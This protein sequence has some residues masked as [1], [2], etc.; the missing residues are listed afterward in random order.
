MTFTDFFRSFALVNID[1]AG[2]VVTEVVSSS[3]VQRVGP[4]GVGTSCVYADLSSEAGTRLAHTFIDINAVAEGILD[5]AGATL[6]LGDTTE[7]PLGVLA[8]Q[9]RTTVVDASLTFI[10]IFA[11]VGVSEFIASPTADF[12][13]ATKRALCVD[14]AL[15]RSTVTD[16]QQTLV[17]VFTV[18]PI[19]FE[20]VAFEAGASVVPLANMSTL[21]VAR[22]TQ[23]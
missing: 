18:H 15:S 19:W 10:Y 9:L 7:R 6:H 8:L 16:S 3:T 1:A 17:D 5:V 22:I 14:T 21:P 11:V 4:A 20:F 12:S 23:H 2:A 13:L